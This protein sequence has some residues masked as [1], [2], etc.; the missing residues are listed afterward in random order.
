MIVV[1][2]TSIKKGDTGT[3]CYTHACIPSCRYPTFLCLQTFCYLLTVINSVRVS[4]C[5]GTRLRLVA[6]PSESHFLKPWTL[7]AS[8]SVDRSLSFLTVSLCREGSR[9]TGTLGVDVSHNVLTSYTPWMSVLMCFGYVIFTI[10]CSSQ[11]VIRMF[12]VYVS[13]PFS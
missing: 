9:S 13:R 8:G 11:H 5:P 4:Q 12:E 2:R 3:R 10:L 1:S 7:V 6:V